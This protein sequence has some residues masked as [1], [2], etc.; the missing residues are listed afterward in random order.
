MLPVIYQQRWAQL[1]SLFPG[2]K[3]WR[4]I[5]VFFLLAF[6]LFKVLAWIIPLPKESLYRPS[7]TLVFDRK[8]NLLRAF[9]A[10]DDMWRIRTSLEQISPSLQ[11]FLVAYEDRWYFF[12]P[13]INPLAMFRAARQNISHGRIVLGGS[14]I[15][16]QIARMI[17][18]KQR[19]YFNKL[20]EVFRAVQLEQRYSK[21]QLLEIYFNIAPYGGNI[22]GV[23][24]AAW[25]YFGKEPSQL[26]YGEAALLAALPNSP[27]LLRPD[28]DAEQARN[29]RDKVLKIAFDHQ[30]LKEKEYREALAETVPVGRRKLPFIAPH[31]SVEKLQRS[32]GESRIYSTLSL[33]TQ[34]LVEDLLKQHIA[35]LK[36]E[37]IS[38]GA[39]VVIDNRSHELIA[40]AGSAD[41]FDKYHSG[42]VNGYLA[43]RSPGSAL[44]PFIYALGFEQ[45]VISPQHY[46]EDV[47]IDFRGG[48]SPENFDSKFSGMV[49]AQ[50]ALER[51]LNVPTINLLQML[52]TDNSLYQMLRQINF[53][54]IAPENRYG[55]SIA[56]GGCE[57]TLLELSAL[58]SA[59]ANGGIYFY[60]KTLQNEAKHP[61]NRLFSSGSTYLVTEILTGLRRPDLPACWEF[62][63]LPKIAWKT[64]T[65]YGHRDAWSIGYNRRYTVGVWIGNFSGEGRAGLIGAE[66]AAPLLFEIFNKLNTGNER[67]FE[68]PTTVETRQ[69]CA[70]SGKTPGPYCKTLVSEL[71]LIDR[72]P[73]QECDFHQ[74]FILDEATGNRLPPHFSSLRKSVE[75]T[76]IKLPP[77][78]AAWMEGN[79][80][81]VD[82]I[83]P[84]L[85]DWQQILPGQPP[86]IR[87]PSADYEYQIREGI[88][89]KYQKICLEAAA[90][91]DVHKLYWFIDGK[92]VGTT[93][94]GEKLF[95]LPE[96]GKHRVVCQD[97]QGRSVEVILVIRE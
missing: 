81:P 9:T 40:A 91:N 51:S 24:A 42:Q 73:E 82:R 65:S 85:P 93:T 31:F 69:V 50:T 57:V 70:L 55:L 17:E 16:M 66:V 22:E 87:S 68:Q 71:Y 34:L 5:G 90:A 76:F 63:S 19:N 94:P 97:D 84:L 1:K 35:R 13:G 23:A 80:Y 20:L 49:S 78:V 45:G 62:T 48:Y 59:L 53:S 14:T 30:L 18:P 33:P 6:C 95:C 11:K 21:Q 2:D 77:R 29:A 38:N 12:H 27:T 96:S 25:F 72:S 39:V 89:P 32:P 4:R 28:L 41:F 15:T 43:P 56:L 46:L 75:K 86:V 44:K 47:P 60:P 88:D 7:A 79:G 67:W 58:Y 92:L 3:K 83:P 52:G 37:D 8:E 26:S 64:G 36:N 61:G 10:R 74:S 54:T